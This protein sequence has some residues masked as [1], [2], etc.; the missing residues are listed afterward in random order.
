[1]AVAGQSVTLTLADEV[2]ISRG[3]VIVAADQA[4]GVADAFR[5]TLVWMSDTPMLPGKPYLMKIGS[6]TLTARVDEIRYRVDINT[7]E[8][9]GAEQFSLNEIGVCMLSLDRPVAFDPY[10]QNRDMGA[11]ILI[12]RLSNNTVGAGMLHE[13]VR[14]LAGTEGPLT[15]EQRARQKGQRGGVVWLSG[16]TTA[17]R[18]EFGLRLESK[19]YAAG[20]HAYF[21]SQEALG[22][23]PGIAR[24]AALMF[25]AGLVVVVAAADATAIDLDAADVAHFRLDSA[26]EGGVALHADQ[27]EASCDGLVAALRARGFIA[28]N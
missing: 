3:D 13:P 6:R 24:V 12:E 19:L 7:L 1:L 20:A 11:F 4:A 23:V 18:N 16:G 10:E 2:D 27:F 8:H 26:G 25:D 17:L 14:A 28:A 21:L 9:A 22:N 15:R 5:A